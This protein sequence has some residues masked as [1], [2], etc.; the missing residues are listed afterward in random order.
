MAET[1]GVDGA[2]ASAGV[3]LFSEVRKELAEM[4]TECAVMHDDAKTY[5]AHAHAAELRE[6]AALDDKK[7]LL[8]AFIADHARE[9]ALTASLDQLKRRIGSML[10]EYRHLQH[11]IASLKTTAD[12]L[13]RADKA[14]DDELAAHEKRRFAVRAQF[15]LHEKI[16]NAEMTAEKSRLERED[17]ERARR[18][19][20]APAPTPR[21]SERRPG[22]APRSQLGRGPRI[23]PA[24][25]AAPR[26]FPALAPFQGVDATDAQVP[27]RGSVREAILAFIQVCSPTSRLPV[28]PSPSLTGAA[29][30]LPR[31]MV[32]RI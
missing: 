26:R 25:R 29:I 11:R 18:E 28:E 13:R 32:E 14:A 2:E 20:P 1:N 19:L 24:N 30:S 3:D 16:V 7:R 5:R 6:H 9:E 4:E 21:R 23:V 22:P 31:P 15:Q 27:H 8:L 17:A 12:E 10:G